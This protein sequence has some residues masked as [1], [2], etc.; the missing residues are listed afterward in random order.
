MG[1]LRFSRRRRIAPGV[2]LN[3][4]KSGPSVSFGGRGFHYTVGHNRRRATVGIPGTGV[5]YTAYSQRHAR[6]TRRAT[7]SSAP[8][9]SS[10]SLLA[11]LWQK[12]PG[13]KIGTAFST[14]C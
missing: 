11:D 5:Y 14:P 3:F 9:Q 4:S 12:S 2:R 13:A 8:R 1:Y 6:S 10:G 7:V